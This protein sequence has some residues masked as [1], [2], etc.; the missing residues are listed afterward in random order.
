MSDERLSKEDRAT[1]RGLM[2]D[3]IELPPAD[4][5][6]VRAMA[7]DALAIL[8]ECDAMERERDEAQTRIDEAYA[9]GERLRAL[10]ERMRAE[11]ENPK[12]PYLDHTPAVIGELAQ[13]GTVLLGV[14]T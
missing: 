10:I 9:A 7:K 11:N 3:A 12:R 1:R 4:H 2:L 13:I 8:D 6:V 14:K 5:D